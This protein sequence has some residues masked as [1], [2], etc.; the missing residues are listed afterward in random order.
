MED[1]TPKFLNSMLYSYNLKNDKESQEWPWTLLPLAINWRAWS[2]RLKILLQ[3]SIRRQEK[4]FSGK[5]FCCLTILMIF[6]MHKSFY[7]IVVFP[8]FNTWSISNEIPISLHSRCLVLTILGNGNNY[9]CAHHNC[10]QYSKKP[11][12]SSNWSLS[13]IA[14]RKDGIYCWISEF[15]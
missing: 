7:S 13:F 9:T 1:T 12:K 2:S 15:W 8:F 3:G 6:D 14:A 5:T 4:V 10:L 11:F